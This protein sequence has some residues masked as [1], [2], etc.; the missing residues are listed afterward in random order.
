MHILI[1]EDESR[2]ADFVKRGLEAEGYRVEVARTGQDGLKL[3]ATSNSQLM[4]LDLMLPDIDGRE[5]CR[6]L[7]QANNAIPILML[8]ALDSLEDRVSGLKLGADD[9]LTKPFSFAEL[10]ARI[11]ALLRRSNDYRHDKPKIA[12]A[13]LSLDRETHAVTRGGRTIELTAKEF[14]LLDLLASAPG[15]PFSRTRILEHVWGYDSDP[16]TN[17]VEVYIRHLRRKIDDG[18]DLKLIQTMR[19]VGYKISAPEPPPT[20]VGS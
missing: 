18:Q 7:R 14:A 17:I 1:V 5:I 4:V 2:I 20:N 10:V 6:R 9:Y 12:V 19:G 8:T 16:L 13:D 11:E 3:A 15:K